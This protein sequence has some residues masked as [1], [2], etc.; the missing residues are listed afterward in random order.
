MIEDFAITN[1]QAVFGKGEFTYQKVLD[2]FLS[3]SFIG[4]MT[5]NISPKADS[6]LLHIL[7]QACLN[8]ADDIVITNIPKRFPLYYDTKYKVDAKK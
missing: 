5:F 4:V 7:K 3:A 2:D 6:N 8:G 1:G